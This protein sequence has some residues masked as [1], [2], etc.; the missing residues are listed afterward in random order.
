M[1]TDVNHLVLRNICQILFVKNDHITVLFIEQ[2]DGIEGL[3]DEQM[4]KWL[5]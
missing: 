4:V 3:T 5:D 1:C 2:H